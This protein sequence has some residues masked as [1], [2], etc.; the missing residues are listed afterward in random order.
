MAIITIDFMSA[1]LMRNVTVNAIIYLA[2][3]WVWRK[4]YNML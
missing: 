3:Y 1:S 2:P 4:T